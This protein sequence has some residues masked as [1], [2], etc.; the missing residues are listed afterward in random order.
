MTTIITE[1]IMKNTGRVME[2]I[3]R[4]PLTSRVQIANHTG[5]TPA[6][7]THLVGLLVEK[8]I[9]FETGSCTRRIPGSGRSRK[10][11]ALHPEFGYFGGLEIN[12]DGLH[13][14]ITDLEG[15]PVLKKKVG[16]DA[17]DPEQINEAITD[18][19]QKAL[20]EFQQPLLGFGIA[21]P[22]HFSA[23]DGHIITNNPLWKDF[24]LPVISARFDF[25]FWAHNN[26]DCMA[27]NQYQYRRDD[28]PHRFAFLHIGAGLYCSFFNSEKL[29]EFKNVYL[30]EIGHTVVERN[31]TQCECG[32]RGCL[33]TY[34]SET[35]LLKKAKIA[36]E[37]NPGSY[38]HYL[39]SSSN[40]ITIQN[41][42]DAY[43][44]GDAFSMRLL[45]DAL[46]YLAI[47]MANMF[48]IHEISK[49]YVNSRLFQRPV[50]K[51][52][53]KEKLYPQISFL[54][55][56]SD[57][58]MMILPFDPYRGAISGAAYAACCYF[59]KDSQRLFEKELQAQNAA[60][61]H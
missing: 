29:H 46:D 36:Y 9:L 1:G 51:D 47:A 39:A 19:I 2:Y 25:P 32:K 57:L 11:V 58:H 42:L 16:I 50:L 20:D 30:G 43:E 13:L 10:L 53:L 40:D 45:E 8:G 59:I 15:T 26:I 52:L 44:A 60:P 7:V 34:V 17:Y 12:M 18:L 28:A 54:D 23:Q 41:I 49:I 27:L 33:Q 31:G 24:S 38:L 14:A 35:W 56:D 6:A 21:V 61:A 48:L 37:S 5:L 3:F 55:A 22:G 4:H